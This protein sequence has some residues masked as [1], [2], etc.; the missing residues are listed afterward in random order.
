MKEAEPK[1]PEVSGE[2]GGVLSFPASGK[3]EK[4]TTNKQTIDPANR[5]DKDSNK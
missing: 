4:K 2:T 3:K 5:D 1:E